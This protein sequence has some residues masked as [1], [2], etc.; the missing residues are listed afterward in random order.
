MRDCS[1]SSSCYGDMERLRVHNP[2][3]AFSP[4]VVFF[5]FGNEYGLEAL[6][7]LLVNRFC[8]G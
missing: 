8:Q 4:H 6:S 7:F 5:S 2:S 1:V 3:S